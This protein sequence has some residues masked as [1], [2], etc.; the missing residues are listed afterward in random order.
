MGSQAAV[1][2]YRQSHAISLYAQ[3]S[4]TL[5]RKSV[6]DTNSDLEADRGMA[7]SSDIA[8]LDFGSKGP[9]LAGFDL[10]P[11]RSAHGCDRRSKRAV[12]YAL[13]CS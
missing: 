13:V 1:V 4:D 2:G 8:F 5:V 6:S 9:C 3:K 11:I 12:G 10:S 7:T